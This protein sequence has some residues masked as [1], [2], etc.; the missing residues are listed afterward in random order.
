M[1]A[2]I[3]RE[4][5]P[6]DFFSPDLHSETIGPHNRISRLASEGPGKCTCRLRGGAAILRS[7]GLPVSAGV[8]ETP[9]HQLRA[10]EPDS[11]RLVD[12]VLLLEPLVEYEVRDQ[13]AAYTVAAAAMDEHGPATGAAEYAENAL[14][15]GVI[16][17]AGGD[18]D[19]DVFE[20]RN[21]R[22]RGSSSGRGSIGSRRSRTIP[23]PAAPSAARFWADG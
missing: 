18:G 10:A 23:P 19:V 5:L 11:H 1:N 12:G 20:S 9:L 2:G 21:A 3:P 6:G 16:V 8:V 17:G 7:A 14:E 4:R 22:G 13:R 15:R